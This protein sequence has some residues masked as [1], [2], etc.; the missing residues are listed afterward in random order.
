MPVSD[1]FD[2]FDTPEHRAAQSG[3]RHVVHCA[4]DAGTRRAISADLDNAR[5]TTPQ[6]VPIYL[7][8]LA[9]PCTLPPA[10]TDTAPNPEDSITP[11]PAG[12]DGLPNNP[13][14]LLDIITHAGTLGEENDAT[15]EVR[16]FHNLDG[17]FDAYEPGHR[18]REVFTDTV[19]EREPFDVCDAVWTLLQVGE[20]PAFGAPDPRAVD[21]RRRGHRSLSTGDVIAIG[22]QFFAVADGGFT[23][24][25]GRPAVL[26]EDEAS[27]LEYERRTVDGVY[28]IVGAQAD[29][30][31]DERWTLKVPR[32]LWDRGDSDALWEWVEEHFGR[33]AAFL[34]EEHGD[35][36]NRELRREWGLEKT[37][38]PA[39]QAEPTVRQRAERDAGLCEAIWSAVQTLGDDLDPDGWHLLGQAIRHSDV[40][41]TLADVV[42]AALRDIHAQNDHAGKHGTA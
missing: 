35:E 30:W 7:A 36:S 1:E 38:P 25:S 33:H 15:V 26:S 12:R 24:I 32:R 16:V 11:E 10:T 23:R 41:R 34:D 28:V 37:E 6:L 9:G 8:A 13:N 31:T 29:T 39:A 5:A 21:Y 2:G 18:L 27:D 20:D 14:M 4:V 22:D 3:C 17:R 40:P 19:P 42:S